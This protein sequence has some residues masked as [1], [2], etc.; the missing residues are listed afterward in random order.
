MGLLFDSRDP[1]GKVI[2]SLRSLTFY[3]Q[4]S[5]LMS[6]PFPPFFHTVLGTSW[7]T[8]SVP[9]AKTPIARETEEGGGR[10]CHWE[11]KGPPLDRTRGSL[12]RPA[13]VKDVA[14][15]QGVEENG[16]LRGRAVRASPVWRFGAR[17]AASACLAAGIPCRSVAPSRRAKV[18]DRMTETK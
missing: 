11:N 15:N 13:K 3:L 10:K 9:T 14:K 12:A 16:A 8:T 2:G 5:R 1:I 17:R 7:E 18:C 4:R 6:H